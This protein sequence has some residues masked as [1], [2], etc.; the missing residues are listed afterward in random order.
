MDFN[1]APRQQQSDV[2]PDKTVVPVHLTIRPGG[3]GEGG[4]LRRNKDGTC[5]M[6][7]TEMTVIEG[8]HAKR[9]IWQMMVVEGENEGQQKAA[10]ITA[11]TVRAMLEAARNVRPDDESVEAQAKRRIASWGELDGLRFQAIVGVRK[12][13]GYP[14]KNQIREVVTPERK[15]YVRLDQA[16]GPARTNGPAA[17]PSP[18]AKPA[19]SRP[20]WAA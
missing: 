4:W 9:K 17:Q 16:A 20:S 12:Q 6:L 18:A 5:L 19:S 10:Q 11:A 7:D 13:D 14:D 8:E 15:T 1:Q 2:I 3:A